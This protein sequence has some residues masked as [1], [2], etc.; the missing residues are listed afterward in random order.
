MDNL[1]LIPTQQ[2][3]DELS[4]RFDHFIATG[5]HLLGKTKMDEVYR[6]YKGNTYLCLGLCE[7]IKGYIMND[8]DAEDIDDEET[9]EGV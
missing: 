3:I 6:Y 1:Q 9:S 7:D 5:I 2:L 4:S 8:Q